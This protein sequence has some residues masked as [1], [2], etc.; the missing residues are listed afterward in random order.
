MNDIIDKDIEK[1][2][3]VSINRKEVKRIPLKSAIKYEE[4][5]KSIV[6]REIQKSPEIKDAETF[7]VYVN[8]KN[9]LPKDVK[10]ITIEE[11]RTIEIFGQ[12]QVD[13]KE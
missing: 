3:I 4:N 11:V 13:K 9:V 6:M 10:N 12:L 1:D 8:G 2:I 5:V 7:S